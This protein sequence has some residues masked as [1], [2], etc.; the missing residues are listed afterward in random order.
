MWNLPGRQPWRQKSPISREV[1]AMQSGNLHFL[2]WLAGVPEPWPKMTTLK[3]ENVVSTPHSQPCLRQ[4]DKQQDLFLFGIKS[5]GRKTGLR[6][7][8]FSVSFCMTFWNYFPR[9]WKSWGFPCRHAMQRLHELS[10]YALK[11]FPF[12]EVLKTSS[13]SAHYPSHFLQQTVFIIQVPK[14]FIF[15]VPSSKAKRPYISANVDFCFANI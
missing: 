2:Q 14:R 8:L 1:T 13:F 4:G 6:P 15:W 10:N 7:W 3:F 5:N 11:S 9:C 12:S